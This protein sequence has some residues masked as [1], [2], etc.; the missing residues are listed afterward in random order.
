MKQRV[1]NILMLLLI[2]GLY[3]LYYI[4]HQEEHKEP[5]KVDV[6]RL[7]QPEFLLSEAPDD[8]LMEALEYYNV[9]HKNIV[10][11]QAILETGHF[12][13]K[14]C[15]EYNNLF[16]LYNSYKGDY[17]KFVHWSQSVKAYKDL[18]QY[19]YYMRETW[20]D[21]AGYEGLYQVSSEGRVASLP[22]EGSGGHKD[23]IYLKPNKDKDGYLLV[24][25]YKN[26]K[27]TKYKIHRLVANAF[28]PNP[29][30]LLQVNHIDEDKTNN[31]LYNLEWCNAS[32]NSN[33]GNGKINRVLNKQKAIYQ[34][35][36]NR[37]F[38]K[39]WSSAKEIE[40][41]LGYNHSNITNCCRSKLKSAYGFKWVYKEPPD[42]YYQFL[43][44]IGYA[45]DPQYVEKLKN[46]VK[47]YG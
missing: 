22:K 31:N 34:L 47:R 2:G 10:Y 18:I 17:Y 42:D 30:G 44:K 14:V 19:R 28:I 27:R 3:G 13:S 32:Y 26:S 5:E 21:I 4:D 29:N 20:K 24:D 1:Y 36:Q 11:A 45:E 9:K 35:N 46:I 23:I 38:I 15:K 12:R 6:L 16:G 43:I 37:E 39:E 8:Y 25:L 33:Y 40:D 7:E 41:T